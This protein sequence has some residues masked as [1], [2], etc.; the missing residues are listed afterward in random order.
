[1]N[2]TPVA[3]AVASLRPARCVIL[4][5]MMA[6]HEAKFLDVAPGT[7]I[8]TLDP[9]G[10]FPAVCRLDGQWILRKDWSRPLAPGQIVEFYEY[11]QGGG[12][13][14]G[15]GS[16]AGRFILTIV[17][18]YLAVQFGQWYAVQGLVGGQAA[19]TAI[20]QLVLMTVV[21]ALV[22]VNNGNNLG[23]GTTE[24]QSYSANLAGNQA[25]LEQ[26]IPVL[27]GRNKTFPDFAAQPYSTYEN[28]D[29]YFY[30]LLC[31]G[32]GS[33]NIES[34]LIDDTNLLNFAEVQKNI[35]PPG[36]APTLVS[37]VVVAAPE[38]T[39]NPLTEGRYIGPFV[40]CRPQDTVTS[41]G[42]DIGFSRGLA[43]YDG[44]G[45]P[46]NKTVAW[47]VE[48]RRVD[49]FGAGLTPWVILQSESITA[50]Q[51]KP[52]RRSYEY[53]LPVPCR[54]QVRLVR[55]TPFDDNS[56]VANTIEWLAMRATLSAPAP[57]SAT[58]THIE[59]KMRATDQLSGLTQRRIGVIS[60]RKLRTWTGTAW[61]AEVETRN[62]AWALAD[63]WTNQTY[64]DKY[65]DDR[66][67]LAGLKALAA[68]LDARQDRFDAVFDTT[69]DSFQADQMIAQSGRCAVFRRNA[70]MT[71]TRDEKKDFPVT[72]FTSRNIDPGSVSIDYRFADENTPD[73]IIVEYWHN[74]VW[75]WR[76][77]MC[78]APG[79]T[80]PARAQR[81]RLF[82][83]TGPIH[84]ERE[85]LYQAANTYWRRRIASFTTELEGMLPA[86]GSAVAF[87]P[88]L[89]GWGRTGDLV[90]YN[91]A[92]Q[93]LTLSEPVEWVSGASHYLSV[94]QR[95]GGLSTPILVTPGAADNEVVLASSLVEAPSL[96]QADEDRTKY[97]FGVAQPY[98]QVLRVLGIRDSKEQGGRIK[99]SIN[100]L[101]EDDRVH[102][103]DIE[104]LPADGVV[105]DDVNA[106]TDDGSGSGGALVP[107]VETAAYSAV[108]GDSYAR[109]DVI[110]RNTGIAEARTTLDGV[111]TTNRMTGQ[112]MLAA[113][114]TPAEAALFEV[115]ASMVSGAVVSGS[116]LGSWLNLATERSWYYEVTTTDA[117]VNG[118]LHVQIREVATGIVQ[119]EAD[120]ILQARTR[121]SGS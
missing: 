17:A 101:L 8:S 93:V 119:T 5:N 95:T 60:R 105:Q 99:Y 47:R 103:S 69:Y 28:D 59:I 111:V 82:G 106:P 4:Q 63:K 37:P 43:S 68:K 80:T 13:G 121:L 102:A 10:R 96:D 120:W 113:P 50:A 18:L 33:Y 89:T 7:I 100:G 117:N 2:L 74:R 14:E 36:T 116:A 64:G 21:N 98:E 27:Y 66:C 81:I 83:V 61:T 30:A 109:I 46:G 76:E 41:I 44:T 65:A 54:P 53:T 3:E 73:G 23:A 78:P 84:A 97:L 118:V 72:A 92:T 56:R 91:T 57:L 48:Y 45:A 6:P 75:D 108:I 62:M 35:L 12:G 115:Y 39:G 20:A 110:L 104:L 11:P 88:N 67:D 114:Y 22:P 34:L 94:I 107:Y 9:K 24:S 70:V 90:D 49:D 1:M 77:I 52:L 25:R 40:A 87:V 55:T 42:I 112:W 85:G 71:V 79:V 51:T 31:L 58:A 86:F 16:N 15:G 26:A 38:V 19:G 32:Q 29:Q